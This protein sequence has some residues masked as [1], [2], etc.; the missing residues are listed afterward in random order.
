MA[1]IDDLYGEFEPT[2][3]HP[4]HQSKTVSL[5]RSNGKKIGVRISG[6]SGIDQ[7]LCISSV[8]SAGQ[9]AGKI[10]VG[11]KVF[12]IN[13]QNVVGFS[14]KQA[15]M[16]VMSSSLVTLALNAPSEDDD[17]YEEFQ[18]PPPVQVAAVAVVPLS[19]VE[20]AIP[21]L[22]SGE[23]TVRATT[24]ACFLTRTSGG[25]ISR[26]KCAAPLLFCSST[27]FSSLPPLLHL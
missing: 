4:S 23:R 22:P 24:I 7:P 6:A 10:V 14:M 11:D 8:D 27:L 5:D 3:I 25:T 20:R 17:L 2:V 18:L 16:I 21:S 19:S 9:A 26:H 1:E 13:G 12:E 15:A